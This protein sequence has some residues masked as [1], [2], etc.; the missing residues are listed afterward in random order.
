MAESVATLRMLEALDA[1]GR[2]PVRVL[3][4]L[5]ADE[6]TTE[7]EIARVVAARVAERQAAARRRGAGGDP[8]SDTDADAARVAGRPAGDGADAPT[9]DPLA[10]LDSDL[11]L[12][13]LQGV[14]LYADGS[15]GA[16]SA[17]LAAPY[18]DGTPAPAPT[19]EVATIAEWLGRCDA[20][21]LQLAVH[22]LGDAA[23]DRV[24]DGIA[25]APPRPKAALPVRVEHA[26]VVA[27][28][29]LGRLQGQLC[30]IQPLHRQDDAAFAHARLGAERLAWSY[31]AATLEPT[32]RLLIG[33]D[34]PI[35]AAN[36]LAMVVEL[37]GGD[38]NAPSDLDEALRVGATG[39]FNAP[40]AAPAAAPAGAG[41]RPESERLSI[42][43]AWQLLRRQ[44]P[45]AAERR[46]KVGAAA[47]LLLL[48]GGG[49]LV[50]VWTQGRLTAQPRR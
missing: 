27:P 19:L 25:A 6:P 45:R 18:S 23:L 9:P 22:A 29:Q 21:G 16:R 40:A 15:L 50:K 3:V 11:R 14:K 5:D 12:A 30:S 1:A 37:S 8:S 42:P 13:R 32:C 46:I 24:I 28:S 39:V 41:P 48:D 36:P 31:R 26:Q 7:T 2:L 44:G 43:T 20:A 47:D 34:Q 38:P 49:H 4:Y 33:S 17:A 10:G 35:S